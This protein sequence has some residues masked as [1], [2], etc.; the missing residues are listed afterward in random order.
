MTSVMLEIY[1]K[2]HFA[3][4][5]QAIYEMHCTALHTLFKIQK[6]NRLTSIEICLWLGFHGI[7]LCI[8]TI[9]FELWL[10]QLIMYRMWHIR[11]YCPVGNVACLIAT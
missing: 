5:M 7:D 11:L 8:F 9:R 3:M 10:R 6:E 4:A 1:I 2:C